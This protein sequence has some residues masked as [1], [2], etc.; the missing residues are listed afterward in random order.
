MAIRQGE[1]A[2]CG[3]A[4][5]SPDNPHIQNACM[6]REL[7]LGIPCPGCPLE[8]KATVQAER[9]ANPRPFAWFIING[10]TEPGRDR[11]YFPQTEVDKYGGI[12]IPVPDL[13]DCSPAHTDPQSGKS[14]E[15]SVL[16]RASNIYRAM[17]ATGRLANDEKFT[18]GFEAIGL[19]QRVGRLLTNPMQFPNLSDYQDYR[20][21]TPVEESIKLM[22]GEV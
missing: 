20:D 19:P 12:P 1:L 2:L 14:F 8:I 11:V 3:G 4:R 5:Y 21:R 10:P 22:I 15:A 13:A 16:L 17:V 7:G 18:P 6:S 9:A